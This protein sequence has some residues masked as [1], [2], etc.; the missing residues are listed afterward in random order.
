MDKLTLAERLLTPITGAPRAAEAVGDL[1][2]ATPSATAFWVSIT[3]IAFAYTWRWLVG[4]PSAMVSIAVVGVPYVEILKSQVEPVVN[5]RQNLEH[6]HVIQVSVYVL[7]AAIA[8]IGIALLALA[9]YGWRRPITRIAAAMTVPFAL[10]AFALC[11]HQLLSGVALLAV[12]FLVTA[13][14]AIRHARASAAILATAIAFAALSFVWS[15][16][17]S[18]C[19]GIS[20]GR[21]GAASVFLPLIALALWFTLY[22]TEALILSRT[23]RWLR[24][25]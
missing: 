23:S 25:V 1:A 18:L 7:L 19:V 3:R 10:S 4:V 14:S 2:E 9:R 16:C 8:L 15:F 6:D 11:A 24:V 17:I 12:A 20:I 5:H 13:F 21:F 22:V